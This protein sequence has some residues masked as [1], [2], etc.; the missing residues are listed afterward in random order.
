MIF[1]GTSNGIYIVDPVS[2]EVVN[3]LCIPRS[4]EIFGICWSDFL[5]GPIF[6]SRNRSLLY[7]IIKKSTS[8]NLYSITSG[9]GFSPEL[10]AR[11]PD[12]CDVHQIKSTGSKVYL[13]DTN[14]NRI[15]V[16]DIEK[17]ET[18]CSIDIGPDREDINHINALSIHGGHLLVGL[19]NRGKK[20][21]QI[22]KI[23]LD[24]LDYSKKNQRGDLIGEFIELPN[25]V[26][27]HDI[28]P[29]TDD[30]LVSASH[31]GVVFK[32]IKNA[33]CISGGGWVRGLAIADGILWVGES[34]KAERNKRHSSELSGAVNKYDSVTFEKLGSVMLPGAGQVNDLLFVDDELLD[35]KQ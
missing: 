21:A 17:N 28:F 29:L 6:A 5:N 34:K 12:V 9:P 23:R 18:I 10:I 7:P 4:L 27:T 35:G 33:D 22:L 32:A 26:H 19:N 25:R 11:V 30:Y 20:D 24:R 15:V 8:C 16:F 14:R 1:A 3:K 31:N 2:D 13:T